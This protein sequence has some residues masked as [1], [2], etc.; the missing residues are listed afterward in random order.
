MISLTLGW[1][2]NLHMKIKLNDI[3]KL[4]KLIN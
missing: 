4:K 2:G 3:W 1:I